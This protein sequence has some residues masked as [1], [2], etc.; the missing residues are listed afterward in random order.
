[1]RQATK[2]VYVEREAFRKVHNALEVRRFFEQRGFVTVRLDGMP[3]IEQ[4]RVFASAEF[5][6]GPHGAGLSNLI[7]TPPH[8]RVIEFIPNS[9]MRSFFWLIS[10]KLGHEYAMLPCPT[11]GGGFNGDM[12]V[13]LKKLDRLFAFLEHA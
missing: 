5:V 3:I 7:F 4:A 10:S 2:R 11:D 13:D 12:Q 6:A 9:E 1:V 8:A